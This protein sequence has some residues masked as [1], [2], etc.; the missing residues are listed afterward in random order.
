MTVRRVLLFVRVFVVVAFASAFLLAV[1]TTAQNN[2]RLTAQNDRLI[3]QIEREHAEQAI[4]RQALIAGQRRLEAKYDGL[5]A[6]NKA[7]LVYLRTHGYF[8]P[9]DLIPAENADSGT[10]RAKH[11]DGTANSGPDSPSKS[12]GSGKASGG[13]KGSTGGSGGSKSSHGKSGGKSH[14]GNK[15]GKAKAHKPHKAK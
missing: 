1:V 12:G 5:L 4:E 6:T 8:I 9:A 15:G 7:L 13:S 14:G 3:A 10:V 2:H 11:H